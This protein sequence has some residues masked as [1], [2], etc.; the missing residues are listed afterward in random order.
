MVFILPLIPLAIGLFTVAAGGTGVLAGAGGMADESKAKELLRML[1][2]VMNTL[3]RS[4]KKFAKKLN[5]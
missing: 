2:I 3:M 5:V 1:K 4:L